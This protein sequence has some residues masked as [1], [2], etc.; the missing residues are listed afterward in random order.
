M[1]PKKYSMHFQT[2][3]CVKRA[4]YKSARKEPFMQNVKLREE[5]D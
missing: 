3:W 1:N 2:S 4:K 5:E